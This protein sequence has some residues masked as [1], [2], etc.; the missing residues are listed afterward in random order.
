MLAIITPY[1][2]NGVVSGTHSATIEGMEKVV[3]CRGL[4]TDDGTK[5]KSWRH[6]IGDY[7]ES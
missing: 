4:L 6:L 5:V 1:D 7:P 2:G 3:F